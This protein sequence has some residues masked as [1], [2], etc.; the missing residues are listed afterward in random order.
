MQDVGAEAPTNLDGR[1]E[2]Q[3]AKDGNSG[4]NPGEAHAIYGTYLEAP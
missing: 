1:L 4:I 3:R 2:Q